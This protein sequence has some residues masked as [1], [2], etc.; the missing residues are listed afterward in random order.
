MIAAS[1]RWVRSRPGLIHVL[2][3]AL[4]VGGGFVAL[5]GGRAVIAD[6][7]GRKSDLTG[8]TEIWE[9]II[10]L[11][12]N[13]LVGAGFES[14]W[15]GPRV[16]MLRE[17]FGGNPL[18]EAHNGY[19]EVYLNLGWVG[20]GLLALIL[21]GGYQ[22]AMATFRRDPAIGALLLAY[23]TSAAIYSVTEA[24]FR[25]LTPIWIFFLFAVVASSCDNLGAKGEL[26]PG[27][28]NEPAKYVARPLPG[29]ALPS[30]QGR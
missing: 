7:L 30:L 27:I 5:F 26:S 25:M 14:F 1:L 9:A 10:P 18:N 13:P 23:V 16:P 19:I 22:R 12:P 24:G 4:V 17:A 29:R 2:C 8:R 21:I 28:N 11:V 20:V 15:L 3:F 6:A